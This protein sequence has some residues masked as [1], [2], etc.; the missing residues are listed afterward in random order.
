M[1]LSIERDLL[2]KAAA[3]A[4]SR[5]EIFVEHRQQAAARFEAGLFIDP[6]CGFLLGAGLRLV[7]PEAGAGKGLL[8]ALAARAALVVTDEFPCFF[9]PRMV[10]GWNEPI[11]AAMWRMLQASHKWTKTAAFAAQFMVPIEAGAEAT[12]TFRVRVT[13]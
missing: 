6:S 5:V 13:V 7:E 9:L 1:P 11:G 12:L 4:G 2:A 10:A 8:R 3:R